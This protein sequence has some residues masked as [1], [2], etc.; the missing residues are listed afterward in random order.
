MTEKL[1]YPAYDPQ[2][3]RLTEQQMI[4]NPQT[5]VPVILSIDCSFSMLQKGRLQS[6]LGG[7]ETFRQ[8]MVEDIIAQDSVEVAVVSYGGTQAIVE[9]DFT[10]VT[11]MKIPQLEAKGETPLTDAVKLSL[12]LL[13]DRL[14]RYNANG[15][16]YYRPW[17][18]L[19]GDGDDQNAGREL[20][21]V[22]RELREMSEKKQVSVLCITVGERNDISYSSLMELSPDGQV[23]YLEDMK[24]EGFFSWLSESM[25][26]VSNS[27]CG[28]DI[29]Y[30][31]TST[32]GELL[33][34][35]S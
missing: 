31:Q 20:V 28:E 13:A 30:P 17:L 24:F 8:K 5:R 14:S 19:I 34:R 7:I 4:E 11:E 35:E 18:I 12:E 22:A 32:W 25:K 15:I 23:Q 1:R 27:L 29:L 16:S 3:Y 6:V 9:Q 33:S 10:P 26:K 2:K 21:K